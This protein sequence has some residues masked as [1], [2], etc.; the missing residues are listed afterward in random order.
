MF[1]HR[2]LVSSGDSSGLSRKTRNNS[3]G[4]AY[5]NMEIS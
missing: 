4:D 1:M 2:F 5:P 3:A